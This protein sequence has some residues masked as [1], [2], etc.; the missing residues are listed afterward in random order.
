MSKQRILDDLADHFSQRLRQLLSDSASRCS[1]AGIDPHNTVLTLTSDLFFEIH[2]VMVYTG[3]S[4]RQYLEIC[5]MM[6]NENAPYHRKQLKERS[7]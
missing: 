5:E 7:K 4:K 1:E 2:R 3:Y 6:W